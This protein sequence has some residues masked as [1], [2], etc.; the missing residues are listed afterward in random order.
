MEAAAAPGVL[1]VFFCFFF[2]DGTQSAVH[3]GGDEQVS[4]LA[5]AP[6]H[7]KVARRA[8]KQE[9][10]CGKAADAFDAQRQVQ[11]FFERVKT[12]TAVGGG[13]ESA[14]VIQTVLRYV[15]TSPKYH[16]RIMRRI[17]L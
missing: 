16:V 4:G 6:A 9:R 7:E 3:A 13:R 8:V 5:G 11:R 1:Q 15:L 17:L 14:C 12:T 10:V 2:F